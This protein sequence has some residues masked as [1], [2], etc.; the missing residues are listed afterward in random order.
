MDDWVIP[1][2]AW[3]VPAYLITSALILVLIY[4]MIFIPDLV[5]DQ[6][7]IVIPA[8]PGFIFVAL[9][10]LTHVR[11]MKLLPDY[12]LLGSMYRV[13]E[14][15]I[16]RDAADQTRK[17]EEN[18][19]R[20]INEE[21]R[22]VRNLETKKKLLEKG[23]DNVVGQLRKTKPGNPTSADDDFGSYNLFTDAELNV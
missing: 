23:R 7:K 4:L 1:I 11:S 6:W 8:I 17:I 18:A 20:L 21:R 13:R 3:F 12:Q 19:Q 2:R 10:A 16:D 14:H 5:D 9:A 22:K 15:F